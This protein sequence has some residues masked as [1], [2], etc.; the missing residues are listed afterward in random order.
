MQPSDAAS[1][2]LRHGGIPAVPPRI[3]RALNRC[4]EAEP[5]VRA[6]TSRPM[7]RPRS[8]VVQVAMSFMPGG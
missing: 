6:P 3:G 4:G 1:T 8:F 2:T 5:M 7:P